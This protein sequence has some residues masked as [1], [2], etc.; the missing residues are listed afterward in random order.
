MSSSHGKDFPSTGGGA[1]LSRLPA[2]VFDKSVLNLIRIWASSEIRRHS[3]K[4]K[5][6][7]HFEMLDLITSN[8]SRY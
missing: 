4:V 5:T 1:A 3:P 6:I 8:P 7:S 2:E